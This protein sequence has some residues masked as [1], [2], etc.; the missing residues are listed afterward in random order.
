MIRSV[1]DANVFASAL[2]HPA[3][4]PGRILEALLERHAFDL[5]VSEPILDELR[6]TLFYPRVR[7]RIRLTDEE[8]DRWLRL[9]PLRA[10]V[11]EL[12]PPTGT[13]SSDPDDDVYLLTAKE[14]LA[15]YLVSGD[16]N[17][18]DL[19]RFE[20]VA[21]LAPQVFLELLGASER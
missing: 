1:L 2:I 21:I 16:R 14:G 17:L 10:T 15:D 11:I 20:R 3:G 4:T 13:I 12:T 8:V 19:R 9:L 6:R 5:L 7:S 18:L